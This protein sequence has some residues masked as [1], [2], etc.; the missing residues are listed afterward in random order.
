MRQ[1]ARSHVQPRSLAGYKDLL[2]PVTCEGKLDMKV[3]PV[4]ESHVQFSWQSFY[5]MIDSDG[6]FYYFQSKLDRDSGDVHGSDS[7]G[8]NLSKTDRSNASGAI[9]L[10]DILRVKSTDNTLRLYSAEYVYFLRAPSKDAMRE[11]FFTI[12][13]TFIGQLL[14]KLAENRHQRSYGPLSSRK[15]KEGFGDRDATLESGPDADPFRTRSTWIRTGESLLSEGGEGAEEGLGLGGGIGIDRAHTLARTRSG[16]YYQSRRWS[17]SIDLDQNGA[18]SDSHSSGS[19]ELL[20]RSNTARSG[21]ARFNL[22]YP[23]HLRTVDELG[24]PVPGESQIEQLPT[25]A[26]APSP[27]AL[28]SP[29]PGST[30][31]DA[32]ASFLSPSPRHAYFDSSK[33]VVEAPLEFSK[34]AGTV[35]PA[36]TSSLLHHSL[37]DDSVIS[38]PCKLPSVSEECKQNAVETEVE[39]EVDRE[40]GDEL[41][42]GRNGFEQESR[43]KPSQRALRLDVNASLP[44]GKP[45]VANGKKAQTKSGKYVPPH[46]RGQNV[47]GESR[48]TQVCLLR[49]KCWAYYLV[50]RIA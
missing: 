24:I 9:P 14:D 21:N 10:E 44:S 42:G 37:S 23:N 40:K 48:C 12:H 47:L 30:S 39:A 2:R 15:H 5:F 34:D 7:N 41:D 17:H 11:W 3:C 45:G 13:R 28:L 35:S 4:T 43:M 1:M 18:S 50:Q 19:E 6:E 31:P 29:T 16:G 22:Q 32:N 36:S 38:R 33:R 8:K 26:R 25:S 46:L 20:T 27:P 49:C